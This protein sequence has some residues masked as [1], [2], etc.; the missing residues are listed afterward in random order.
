VIRQNMCG[1]AGLSGAALMLLILHLTKD[2]LRI[3][4]IHIL[5]PHRQ[6]YVVNLITIILI[7]Y[8]S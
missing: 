5:I 4:N 2:T 1:W 3:L 6:E 7:L 8:V